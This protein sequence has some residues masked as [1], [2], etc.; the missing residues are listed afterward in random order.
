MAFKRKR[1]RKTN[2]K[3]NM[4]G[5]RRQSSKYDTKWQSN[6][7]RKPI[8]AGRKPVS[9]PTTVKHVF[10]MVGMH[11]CR[12]IVLFEPELK[13]AVYMAALVCGSLVCDFTPIPRSYFSRKNNMF[14]YYFVKWGWG[15]TL[16]SVS[17]F[18]GLTSY[19][20]CCGNIDKIKRHFYRLL[21]AT[22]V[23]FSFT[24]AFILIESYTAGC[25]SEKHSTKVS[26]LRGG[27]VWKGFDISGHAFLL[28]YCSLI[29]TEEAKAMRGWER[30][31]DLIRNEEFEEDS[32]LKVLS[33]D[34]VNHLK[35]NYDKLTP[36]VRTAFLNL[37]L[38]SIL[39]DGMLLAT[40][41]YFHSMV[42]KVVGGCLAILVWY[43][44]YKYWYTLPSSPGLPGQGSFKYSNQPMK[45]TSSQCFYH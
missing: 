45:R 23:W 37:T 22:A 12:K 8:S 35:E 14:N 33:L 42:Q 10:L 11:I 9:D 17:A 28:I 41:I 2:L 44:T 15:W 7:L 21:I 26:C 36:Y 24:K 5:V 31:G 19:I 38:F 29:I 13:I 40:I 43:A 16:I 6:L 18:L 32:P 4:A 3:I 25:L 27:S 39:W 20:Y 30:I 34:E 1:K